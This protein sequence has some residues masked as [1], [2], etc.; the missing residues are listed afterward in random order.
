MDNHTSYKGGAAHKVRQRYLKRG[1][2]AT[3]A[4]EA[5][6]AGSSK[7]GPV[8]AKAAVHTGQQAASAGKTSAPPEFV[9]PAHFMGNVYERFEVTDLHAGI[10]RR[11]QHDQSGA[12]RLYGSLH[13]P[14]QHQ[15]T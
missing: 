1:S 13:S 5:G 2:S 14:A 6:L 12:P 7:A 11:F 9:Q 10:G 8:K 4:Y 3:V 15:L